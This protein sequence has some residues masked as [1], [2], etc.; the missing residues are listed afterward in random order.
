MRFLD[1][2]NLNVF[3]SDSETVESESLDKSERFSECYLMLVDKLSIDKQRHL[4]IK[5]IGIILEH[6]SFKIV[7]VNCLERER[8]S[9]DCYNWMIKATIKGELLRNLG[10]IYNGQ[11]YKIMEQP[12]WRLEK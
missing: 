10:V 3:A 11:Y 8:N 2:K 9:Q 12:K 4:T 6:L 7:D 5:D 1:S